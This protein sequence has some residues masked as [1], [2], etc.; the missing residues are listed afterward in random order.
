ML[1]GDKFVTYVL[2]A[3]EGASTGITLE[4]GRCL[5]LQHH[6]CQSRSSSTDQLHPLDNPHFY[7]CQHPLLPLQVSAPA[8]LV[9]V[10]ASLPLL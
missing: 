6:L 1:S 4:C 5:L 9:H 10:H 7:L 8:L 2:K 3:G